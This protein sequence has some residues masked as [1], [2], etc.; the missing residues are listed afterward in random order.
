MPLDER[1]THLWGNIWKCIDDDSLPK[2][3]PIELSDSPRCQR[4]TSPSS[5]P[6]YSHALPF[7]PSQHP[8]SIRLR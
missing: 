4:P 6:P 8:P 3:R 1:Q 5:L 2:A 7:E